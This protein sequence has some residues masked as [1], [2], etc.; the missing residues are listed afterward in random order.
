MGFLKKL[1]QGLGISTV[2]VAVSA[3]DQVGATDGQIKATVT[4]TA[5][6]AQRILSVT[7]AFE[8]VLRYEKRTELT[9]SA[10]GSRYT[11]SSETHR[12]ELGRWEDSM[13]VDLIEGETSEFEFTIDFDAMDET[14]SS[15]SGSSLWRF[16]PAHWMLG[17]DWHPQDITYVVRAIVDVDDA[18]FNKEAEQPVEVV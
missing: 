9:D 14:Y 18:A 2:V 6:S 13:R 5:E 16:I 7:A 15:G 10:G 8:R 3:P 11:W 17:T 1:K 4:I 12:E